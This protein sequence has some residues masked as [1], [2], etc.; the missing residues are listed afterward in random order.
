MKRTRTTRSATPS[1]RRL[2]ALVSLALT[3]AI[4]TRKAAEAQYYPVA[5][6]IE[7]Y[8]AGARN[9]G[10]SGSFIANWGALNTSSSDRFIKPGFDENYFVVGN[11][12]EPPP[13]HYFP[14]GFV[15]NY[16]IPVN[17]LYQSWVLEGQ[18]AT[19]YAPGNTQGSNG[20]EVTPTRT[21]PPAFVPAANLDF[22]QPG[23]YPS[24]FLG[25]VNAG[26]PANQQGIVTTIAAF[27]FDPHLT[28]TNLTYVPNDPANPTGDLNPN[29]IY[30]DITLTQPGKSA[31]KFLVQLFINGANST[32]GIDTLSYTGALTTPDPTSL[33]LTVGAATLQ[34]GSG[35]T[36]N[37]RIADTPHPSITPVGAVTFFD[38]VNGAQSTVET[39]P[40]FDGS[41]AVTF[42]PTAAGAHTLTAAFTPNDPTAFSSSIGNLAQ[43]V[44]VTLGQ[45]W[46]LNSD[47]T[48][49]VFA[50]DGS[51]AYSALGTASPASP[52]GGIAIDAA[53][54]SWSATA[55]VLNKVS[56]GGFAAAPLQGAALDA[57]SAIAI[58]G[59][60]T[61]WIANS[62][63]NSVSV[64]S[65]AGIPESGTV[66]YATARLA[67]P[68]G[69]AIDTSGNVW[70][71]NA[72]GSSVT[73][74]LGAATPV[75]TPLATAEQSATP[76]TRP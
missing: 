15:G 50:Q 42:Q 28:I 59:A 70:V 55:G 32:R 17:G 41:A 65:N 2:I 52:L 26:P 10:N 38:S 53:G 39:A 60:G 6:C 22:T 4:V 23:T 46:V 37:A 66:G 29:S 71:A 8:T 72:T 62:G 21:C 64:V 40:T 13:P 25:Q 68:T 75:I 11:P 3:T 57:A 1:S 69:I 14:I 51:I 48:V 43:Q 18:T 5:N 31:I 61:L 30:G 36:L 9:Y 56:S 67:T 20:A 74:L 63:A 76:A 7:Y 19:I 73:E 35:T 16:R 24:Q 45:V 47:G 27:S 49:S 54:T 58:D 12:V 33:L 34:V 44:T